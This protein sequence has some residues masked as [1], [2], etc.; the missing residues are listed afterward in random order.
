ALA[1]GDPAR[2]GDAVHA[3]G[4]ALALDPE[5][6]E[7]A[8]LVTQLIVEPPRVLPP[9]LVKG[10]DD[11][12]RVAHR[13]R[14]R[15]AVRGFLAVLAFA[16]V[17]PFLEIRSWPLL[18][19][20][21]G[22][23]AGMAGITELSYRRGASVAP[24]SLVAT[25]ATVLL[26]SR[27]AGPFVLTPVV[28]SGIALGLIATGPLTGRPWI[29]IAWVVLGLTVPI[30]LEALG[31]FA[32]TWSFDGDSIRIRS[33]VVG[34]SKPVLEA[35]LVA[36]NVLF[37]AMAVLFVRATSRDRRAAERRLHVQAWHLRQLLPGRT[38]TAPS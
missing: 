6:A 5:S 31:V 37:I 7:A 30:A 1:S 14:S 23:V 8:D 18:V 11:A 12:E 9:A 16:A 24:V 27:I 38:L 19:G 25:F 20:F 4:R 2:R 34:G 10:L 35:V 28:I 13:V 32:P 15:T 33:A 36:A 3:A 22:S 26:A 17:V 21:F 29:V